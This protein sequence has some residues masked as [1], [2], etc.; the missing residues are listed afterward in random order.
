MPNH[1]NMT[2]S[3]DIESIKKR[4]SEVEMW[5]S[6]E[7]LNDIYTSDYWNND[8]I[9]KNKELWKVMAIMRNAKN[10]LKLLVW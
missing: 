5:I 6:P 1:F 2:C 8:E 3:C 10:I 4:L 9:E 7:S